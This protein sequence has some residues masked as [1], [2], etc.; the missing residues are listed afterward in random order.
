MTD[1]TGKT[2][3][4]TGSARGI[5]KAIALRYAQLGANIV[6]NYS[7]NAANVDQALRGRYER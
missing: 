6:I 5:G 7:S 2:A 1:L 3:L 4:I